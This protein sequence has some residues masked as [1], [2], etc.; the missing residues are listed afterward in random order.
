L[1]KLNI[2]SIKLTRDDFSTDEEFLQHQQ[3]IQEVAAR[4]LAYNR[5]FLPQ[6]TPCQAFYRLEKGTPLSIFIEVYPFNELVDCGSNFQL[7]ELMEL[8]RLYSTLD[9]SDQEFYIDSFR[10]LQ[11]LINSI[12]SNKITGSYGKGFQSWKEQVAANQEIKDVLRMPEPSQ[13]EIDEIA[14]QHYLKDEIPLSPSPQLAQPAQPVQPAQPTSLIGR[15][16]SLFSGGGRKTV[17]LIK[18]SRSRSRSRSRTSKSKS[19][20]NSRSKS[21]SRRSNSRSKSQSKK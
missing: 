12:Q 4:E 10:R 3:Q 17:K 2:M 18:S 14:F 13:E 9:Q 8:K 11:Q 1:H 21:Y 5:K 6:E 7:E 15:I 16:K 19:K 20:S